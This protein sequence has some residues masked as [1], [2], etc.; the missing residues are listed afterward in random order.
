MWSA[1][2]AGHDDEAEPFA[3]ADRQ[4]LPREFDKVL[5]FLHKP[6]AY[7]RFK[8]LLEDRGVPESWYAFEKD[9]IERAL[10]RWCAE[11]EIEP[12]PESAA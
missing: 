3:A 4:H 11:N 10:R 7:A 1:N 8:D 12:G 9:A 5:S 6:G 2:P